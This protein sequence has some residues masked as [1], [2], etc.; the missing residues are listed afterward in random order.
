MK[1]EP[2]KLSDIDTLT[3]AP[4][5]QPSTSS[6]RP[7]TSSEQ[8]SE[9][10]EQPPPSQELDWLNGIKFLIKRTTKTYLT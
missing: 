9:S 10:L 5:V 4:S 2:P 3:I 1:S 6:I 8:L 7:Y